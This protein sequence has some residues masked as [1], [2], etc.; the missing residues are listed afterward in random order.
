M[1]VCNSSA[2]STL[3]NELYLENPNCA[4]L[5][6]TMKHQRINIQDEVLSKEYPVIIHLVA[7]PLGVGSG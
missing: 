1:K 2:F 3:E 7:L 4:I 5:S 6:I